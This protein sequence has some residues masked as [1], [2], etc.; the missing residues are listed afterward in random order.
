M[1][2]AEDFSQLLRDSGIDVDATQI[3]SQ[4]DIQSGI[5]GLQVWL[6]S[7]EPDTKSAA[8]G[9]T[10]DFPVKAGLADPQVDIASGLGSVLFAADNS[11]VTLD[12]SQLL[13]I[14]KT[15]F[16]QAAGGQV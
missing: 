14:C 11:P 7:L 15:A 13:E 8:D 4:D 16:K 5:D 10:A 6:D 1:P 9:V 2:F 3:P 12:I